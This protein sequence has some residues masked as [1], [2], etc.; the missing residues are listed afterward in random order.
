MALQT[1]INSFIDV[2]DGLWLRKKVNANQPILED[3]L[4]SE[5]VVK[6]NQLI[7]VTVKGEGFFIKTKGV[8]MQEGLI[9]DRILVMVNDGTKSVLAIIVDKDRVDVEI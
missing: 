2:Y 1:N 5:P 3:D 6:K 8:A 7:N 9:G 4:K